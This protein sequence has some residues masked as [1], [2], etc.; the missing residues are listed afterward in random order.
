M[1]L[2]DHKYMYIRSLIF[3]GIFILLHYTYDWFPNIVVQIF[4]GTNESP[5]QHM[6]IGFYSYIILML[7]EFLVFRKKIADNTKYLFSRIISTVILPW[8]IFIIFF[9]SRVFYPWEMH[10]VV[11][12]ITAQL[13]TYISVLIIGYIELDTIKIEYGTRLKVIFVIL[14]TLLIVEFT[15]FTFYLP[16]HDVLTD[17]YAS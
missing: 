6:K 10:F 11:E 9:L 7:I 14:M 13:S 17:P 8:I 16:W 2:D 1:N 5:F 3:L 4:S 15:A 12:I